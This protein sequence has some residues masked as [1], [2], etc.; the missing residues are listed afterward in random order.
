MP[1]HNDLVIMPYNTLGA[2]EL[3]V[4]T[5]L[6]LA[7]DKNQSVAVWEQSEP[8]M[9]LSLLRCCWCCYCNIPEY[10]LPGLLAD[11]LQKTSPEGHE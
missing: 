9:V 8:E 10:I 2:T 1:E 3:R 7:F 5:K 4:Q 11:P 6:I